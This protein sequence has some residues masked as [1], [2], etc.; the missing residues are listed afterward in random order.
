M[1]VHDGPKYAI[2]DSELREWIEKWVDPQGALDG[3]P[4]FFN[5]T[6]RTRDKRWLSNPLRDE[7]NRAAEKVGVRVKMYEG[8]KH[9][10]ATEALRGGRRREEIQK[11]LGHKDRRSTERYAKL[12]EV[13]P[14]DDIFR[15]RNP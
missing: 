13:T 12:A 11:T 7:W 8:T 1:S 5:P 14:V 2:I 15:R 4:L 9:T 10:S 3:S 6:A